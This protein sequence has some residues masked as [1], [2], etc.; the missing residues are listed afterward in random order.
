MICFIDQK[1]LCPNSNTF[2]FECRVMINTKTVA[3]RLHTCLHICNHVS[4]QD[5][6]NIFCTCRSTNNP[7]RI[8]QDVAN[9]IC[10]SA[11]WRVS[12]LKHTRP[13]LHRC[14]N[15]TYTIYTQEYHRIPC[16]NAKC[17]KGAY[18]RTAHW[19]YLP[20]SPLSRRHLLEAKW[21]RQGDTK[22]PAKHCA[23]T[24]WAPSVVR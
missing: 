11:H 14:I 10:A 3:D 16:C 13:F 24:G 19:K 18:L 20:Q 5:S 7:L 15:T 17:S 9:A 22:R 12:R 4:M 8:S 1:N 6:I 21:Q 2:S 23:A